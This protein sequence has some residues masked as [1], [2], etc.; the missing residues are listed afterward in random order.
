MSK[1][2]L[3]YAQFVWSLFCM[4]LMVNGLKLESNFPTYN[5]YHLISFLD[6]IFERIFVQKNW[7]WFHKDG[8][9]CLI[10]EATM[11]LRPFL[12]MALLAAESYVG[13]V[14]DTCCIEKPK[15]IDVLKDN[16]REALGEI[17]L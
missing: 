8:A 5:S 4:R 7:R 3:E 2:I 1:K 13:I 14:K 12:M 15:T 9:T 10:A 6:R 11:D 17:Q 16:I